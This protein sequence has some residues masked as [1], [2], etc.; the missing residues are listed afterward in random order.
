MLLDAMLVL[1]SLDACTSQLAS[2][3]VFGYLPQIAVQV[4]PSKILKKT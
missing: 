2:F 1:K 4:A 3:I